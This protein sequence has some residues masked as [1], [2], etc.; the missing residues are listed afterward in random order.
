MKK[1]IGCAA[2]VLTL[3]LQC[4]W[5]G[6]V[7][8]DV[9]SGV[10]W[11]GYNVARIP[12]DTGSMVGLSDD[13]A[14]EPRGFYRLR[15]IYDVNATDSFEALYAPLTLTGE[16]V[17]PNDVFFSGTTFPAGTTAEARYTFNSYRLTWARV[18]HRGAK[19]TFKAGVTAKVRDA[20]FRISGGGVAAEKANVGLVPLLRL[21][22]SY[23]MTPRWGVL[24]LADAL[25]APQGRAEDV[26]TA[27]TWQADERLTLRAGYRFVE[28][29]ADN[30]EVFTFALIN[31]VVVGASYRF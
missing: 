31:Y 24:L 6:H 26:L 7:T 30:K 19:M 13:F 18:V 21:E 5:A 20:V 3:S 25:A 29:G 2:V 12:G 11:S 8:C 17:L 27:L 15:V 4:G 10:V 16:G 1:I 9:E 14:I 23:A 28:G 22:G